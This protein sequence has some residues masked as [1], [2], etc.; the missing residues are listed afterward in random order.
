MAMALPFF[1]SSLL[2]PFIGITVD[3]MG[4]RGILMISAALLGVLTYVM[5][6]CVSPIYP[7][8]TLGLTYSIFASVLWPSLTLVVPKDILGIALGFATSMQNVGLVFIPLIVAFIFTKSQSYDAT[9]MFFVF[10]LI[11][12]LIL[13]VIVQFEDF[14]NERILHNVQ[15]AET[16]QTLKLSSNCN[17]K[18]NGILHHSLL[19]EKNYS[20][21]GEILSKSIKIM[22]EVDDEEKIMLF[23][24]LI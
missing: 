8:I 13:S 24:S 15:K 12:S 17:E 11:L 18:D 3:K 2:V 23:K 5:F 22:K 4:R 9:L 7:L 20:S 14:K 19:K 16:D 10:L 6:I 21:N 1:I